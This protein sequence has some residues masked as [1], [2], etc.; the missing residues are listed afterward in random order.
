M[1]EGG[2]GI[3]SATCEDLNK[4]VEVDSKALTDELKVLADLKKAASKSQT[5]SLKEIFQTEIDKVEQMDSRLEKTIAAL[6]TQQEA[7]CK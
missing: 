3:S 5:S 4:L 6:K 7:K 2:K 1:G